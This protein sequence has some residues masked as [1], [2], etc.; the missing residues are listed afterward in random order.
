MYGDLCPFTRADGCGDLGVPRPFTQAG[1]H[2]VICVP[3]PE[4]MG[5]VI[6]VSLYLSRCVCGNLGVPLPE[7][8]W[9]W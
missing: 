6:W 7:Q 1:V 2:V 4:Q 5:V 9:V 3:L 8:V